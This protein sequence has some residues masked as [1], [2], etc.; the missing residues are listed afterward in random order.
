MDPRLLSMEFQL[1]H[2]HGDG[3]WAPM[4]REPHD[5]AQTDPERDWANGEIF[6]CTR[7]DDQ[8]QIVH[9]HAEDRGPR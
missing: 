4:R 5:P 8:I 3:D 1:R 2:R 9:E 7:C 6:R